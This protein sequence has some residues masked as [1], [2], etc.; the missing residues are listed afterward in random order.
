MVSTSKF[1]ERTALTGVGQSRIGRRLMIDPLRLT[2]DAC[3]AAVAD[4]G[5]T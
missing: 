3:L 5:S 1:E 2:V 4:A